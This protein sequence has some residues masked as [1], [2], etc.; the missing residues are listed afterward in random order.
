MTDCADLGEIVIARG[1]SDPPLTLRFAP[2]VGAGSQWRLTLRPYGAA[3]LTFTTLDGGLAARAGTAEVD[4]QTVPATILTWAYTAPQSR[5]IPLG[6]LTRIEVEH[7]AP[8]GFESLIAAGY[9]IGTGG[10]SIDA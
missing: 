7:I 6:R 3:H 1:S 10:L 5:L 8:G 9:I 4:G 2:L